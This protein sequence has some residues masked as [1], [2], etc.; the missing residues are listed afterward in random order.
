MLKKMRGYIISAVIGGLL[1]FSGQ[2]L[3]DSISIVGKKVLAENKVTVD[4][5]ELS[6]TAA[7][8]GG[9]TYGPIRAIVEALGG[10]VEF[11]DNVVVVNSAKVEQQEGVTSLPKDDGSDVNSVI[12]TESDRLIASGKYTLDNID[13]YISN[14][15]GSIASKENYINDKKSRN[16]EIWPLW[17]QQL[18]DLKTGLEIYKAVKAKLEAQQ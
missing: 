2:V 5:K 17:E 8:L 3:A 16:E 10:D 15:E 7:N 14:Q 11:K 1:V 9:T 18:S 13:K 6:V 4:G 12:D